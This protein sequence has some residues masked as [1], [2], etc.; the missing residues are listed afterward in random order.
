MLIHPYELSEGGI[1]NRLFRTRM[2]YAAYLLSRNDIKNVIVTGHHGEHDKKIVEQ[3]GVTL[4]NA[5]LTYLVNNGVDPKK[6]LKELNGTTTWSCTQ[7]VWEEFVMPREFKSGVIVSNVEH[8]PRVIMQTE[9]IMRLK[10][11]RVLELYYSGPRI[12]DEAERK[13]FLEHEMKSL[14]ATMSRSD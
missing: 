12:A 14:M 2:D 11:Y 13:T 9:K 6:I 3:S 7:N 1:P 10:N 8:L 4:A 5:M